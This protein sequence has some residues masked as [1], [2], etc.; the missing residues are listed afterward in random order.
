[1]RDVWESPTRLIWRRGDER[2]DED[3]LV[4]RRGVPDW[5]IL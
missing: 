5:F 2:S 4:L 1:L 3:P